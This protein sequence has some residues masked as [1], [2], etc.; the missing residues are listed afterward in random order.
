MGDTALAKNLEWLDRSEL[1]ELLEALASRGREFAQ[2]IDA[3]VEDR[4]TDKA[5]RDRPSL[6]DPEELVSFPE[7]CKQYK[8][9]PEYLRQVATQGKIKAWLVGHTWVST[10]AFLLD[11]MRGRQ[12]E[13][14]PP[15]PLPKSKVTGKTKKSHRRP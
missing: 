5:Q 4:L 3:A 6:V 13:G 2:A 14:W 1:V 12:T 15:K 11:Y 9:N 7:I 8:Y 10:R